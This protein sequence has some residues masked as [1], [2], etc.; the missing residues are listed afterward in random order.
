MSAPAA[1]ELVS[2][3]DARGGAE[4]TL[5]RL[6]WSRVETSSRLP[7]E[8]VKRGGRWEPLTWGQVGEIVRE[9]A[10]GLIALGRRPGESVV[11]LSASRAEWVHADFAIL[12]AGGVTVPIYATYTPEQVAWLVN[13]ADARTLI[14]EDAA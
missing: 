10:L 7:A 13:D 12:S 4:D 14:V 8:L 1:R 5:A 3:T 6:F 11:L 2:A 9:A